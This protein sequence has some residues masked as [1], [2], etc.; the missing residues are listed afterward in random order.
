MNL[1]IDE[2]REA[3]INA[4]L[5]EMFN[6]AYKQGVEDGRELVKFENSLSTNLKKEDVAK[7]FNVELPTVEKIIRMNGFPKCRAVTARYPRDKVLQWKEENE[8][9]WNE[10]LGIYVT[11]QESLRLMRTSS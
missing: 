7:I 1:T 9:Y 5:A 3:L 11:H 4:E 8:M 2:L 10:R 6:Q